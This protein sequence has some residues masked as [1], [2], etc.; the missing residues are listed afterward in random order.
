MTLHSFF[1]FCG[2]RHRGVDSCRVRFRTLSSP[3]GTSPAVLASSGLFANLAANDA[4]NA[5][6]VTH[7]GEMWGYDAKTRKGQEVK[8]VQREVKESEGQ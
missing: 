5:G 3:S 4:S 7:A 2:T 8:N 1:S 6:D